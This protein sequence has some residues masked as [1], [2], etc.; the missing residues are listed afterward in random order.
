M[1]KDQATI[2]G[3]SQAWEYYI[4]DHPVIIPDMIEAAITKTFSEWLEGH[5]EELIQ[6]IA[7]NATAMIPEKQEPKDEQGIAAC[8]FKGQIIASSDLTKRS[9]K[10]NMI[11]LPCGQFTIRVTEGFPRW[12]VHA[13]NG[14]MVS[15]KILE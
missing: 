4:A 3:V 15:M 11:G 1:K 5:S 8:S 14:T 12:R 9:E 10:G 13:L 7:D 6:K 2:K